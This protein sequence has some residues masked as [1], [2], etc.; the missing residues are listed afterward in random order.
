[1]TGRA[2]ARDLAAWLDHAARL[3]PKTVDLGLGRVAAVL[4]RLGLERPPFRAI[5]VGGTNGKGSCVAFIEAMLSAAGRRCGA[6]TSPHLVRY[7]ERVKVD[8]QEASPAALAEAFAEVEAA[9]DAAQ[10]TYFEFGTLAALC[11]FRRAGIELAVLEVG[12]GGR[13]DAV[14]AVDPVVSV[15]TSVALDH[16]ELLGPD[17]ERI[18]MEKAGIF[19]TGRVAICGDPDPPASLIAEARRI[20]ADP[21][22]IGH[23]FKVERAGDAW[24]LVH[25]QG[26]IEGLP[27][28]ALA[29]AFQY[30]NAACAVAALL[31]SGDTPPRAALEAGLRAARN[32]GRLQR[33]GPAGEVVLDVAHNPAAAAALAAALAAEPGAGRTLAVLGVLADKDA[34]GIAR[35]LDPVVD[36]W[37]A[38]GL[39]GPRG[40][41]GAALAAAL[42]DA[43]LRG[44][45]SAHAD[46][47]AAHA[48]AR[49]ALV[50]GDRLLVVGSF[51]TVGA[52]LEAGLYEAGLYCAPRGA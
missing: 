2:R 47:L 30:A 52:V 7:T 24:T 23:E 28:P 39:A 27:P 40:R 12:L 46:V 9:R 16:Q 1:V 45:V 3:H 33:V 21:W 19:R 13:L 51:H 44:Q 31:A 34:G 35:A 17:R 4:R 11:A 38:A 49:A 29:G 6:Y 8:G 26:R 10:L 15:V 14:N 41:D 22:R 43:G 36:A 37:F 50:P 5:A 18:G 25:R 48:A 20:G 32:S 42:R